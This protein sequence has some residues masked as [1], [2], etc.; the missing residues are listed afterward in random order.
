MNTYRTNFSFGVKSRLGFDEARQKVEALLQEEGFGILTEIDVKD[1]LK[2]KLD[3][4]FRRYQILG[5]CNPKIAH[6]AFQHEIEIG[7]LLPCNVI[8][9]ENET[10]GTNI[11][12]MDPQAALGMIGNPDVKEFA[13]QVAEKLRWVLA[14]L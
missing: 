3:V 4:D 10:G 14:K 5:A 12:F 13:D 6:Q 7:A 11:S 1:T 9:Y 2:K 8:L